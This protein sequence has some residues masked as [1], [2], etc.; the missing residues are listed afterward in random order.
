MSE[1]TL[2]HITKKFGETGIIKDFT[3]TFADG[4]FVTLLGSSGCGK[5]TLLRML[6]GFEKLTG[7]TIK[8]GGETVSSESV[9]LPPEKRGIGMVFQSYAV[10][11]HKNV[12]D[13][14]AYP[15]KIQRRPKDE[16]ARKVE[17]VLL[18]V[19]LDGYEKRMPSELSGGQ[20][21][22]VA[23]GRALV[24]EPKV[25]LL[26]E[27]LSN[28]DAKLRE[29]M[30]YEIK[31]LQKEKGI[32]VVFVT[33]DQNE[34]MAMSDTVYVINE[35]VIQQVGKPLDICKNPKTPFVAD[36][37]GKIH[38]LD[39]SA[40]DGRIQ[41]AGIEEPIEYEGDINGDI[42]VALRPENLL[43]FNER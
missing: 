10:W 23:L 24:A 14:V 9:F 37:I 19:H 21:Q 28:L 11:P 40:K 29:E 27:P 38:F 4:E 41:V 30:R 2:E 6:A 16:I 1:I 12:F 42:T 36:F 15:L 34:A 32:T 26:D 39:A 22:R 18:E 43:V 25:L 31:E 5:T 17:K 35:G 13:N 33:H 20:Q 8:I 7:G 3:A